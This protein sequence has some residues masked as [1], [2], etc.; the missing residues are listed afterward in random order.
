MQGAAAWVTVIVCPPTVTVVERLLVAVLAAAL[1]TRLPLPEPLAVVSVSQVA[2]A[3]AVQAQ[4]AGVVIAEVLP[5]EA[6]AASENE[7]GETA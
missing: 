6:A 4:P 1:N 3:V 5:V 2:E 7:A